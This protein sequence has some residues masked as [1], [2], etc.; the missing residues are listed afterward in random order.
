M[1]SRTQEKGL[2]GKHPSPK[3]PKCVTDIYISVVV[4]GGKGSEP[5]SKKIL[6]MLMTIA[7]T[8]MNYIE[9]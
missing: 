8:K 5:P 9:Y 6:Y 1:A 3:H 2:R 7:I 4:I